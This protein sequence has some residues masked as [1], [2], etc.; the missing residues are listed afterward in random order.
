M[1]P[2]RNPLAG[3]ERKYAK[4]VSQPQVSN[5]S[6]FPG[7]PAEK[8]SATA[9]HVSPVG[10]EINQ[11]RSRP[12]S[13]SSTSQVLSESEPFWFHTEQDETIVTGPWVLVM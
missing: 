9:L 4:A 2:P 13:L 12:C 5:A 1:E 7:T 10:N 3:S 6:S 8:H 11:M